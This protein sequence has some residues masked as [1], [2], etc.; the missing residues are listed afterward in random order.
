MNSSKYKKDEQGYS[1]MHVAKS[2]FNE[3]LTHNADGVCNTLKHQ[4]L[5]TSR[6]KS[7]KSVQGYQ[8]NEREPTTQTGAI[9]FFAM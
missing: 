4:P 7:M 6:E 3:Q 5:E 2:N 8:Q 9:F 1:R